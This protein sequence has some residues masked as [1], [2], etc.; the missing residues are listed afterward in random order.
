M[1][2]YQGVVALEGSLEEAAHQ[3]FRQSEQIPTRVRLAVAESYSAGGG[4]HWRAGG[5]IVQF[6]PTSPSGARRPTCRPAMRRR[7]IPPRPCERRR[8]RRLDRGEGPRRDR[9]GSRADRPDG[10]A[11]GCSTAS[12]TSAACASSSAS[13][14]VEACRCSRERVIGMLRSF[15][16][17]TAATWSPTTARSASPASSAIPTMSLRARMSCPGP[18]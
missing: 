18:V 14:C 13:R 5:L 15:S 16:P 8:G 4:R 11:S 2:R 6:L 3:Y 10:R 12:S 17:R 1:A 9:R 7:A